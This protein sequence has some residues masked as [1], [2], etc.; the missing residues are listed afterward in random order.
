MEE[1]SLE[2]LERWMNQN[3]ISKEDQIKYYK[4]LVIKLENE[5]D[6]IDRLLKKSIV[7]FSALGLGTGMIINLDQNLNICLGVLLILFG[8]AIL[9][10]EKKE[11]KEMD[12]IE[13]K[14]ILIKKWHI[15]EKE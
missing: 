4:K 5:K 14:R 3:N 15:K 13:E 9:I 1:E 6:N 10:P 7:S 8:S 2:I 12:E 11:T